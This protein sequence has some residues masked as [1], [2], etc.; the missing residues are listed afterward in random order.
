[1]RN[2]KIEKNVSTLVNISICTVVFG[3]VAYTLGH[4]L[5]HSVFG[6]HALPFENKV[7]SNEKQCIMDHMKMITAGRIQNSNYSTSV[8]FREDVANIEGFRAAFNVLKKWNASD[9]EVT[10]RRGHIYIF[11]ELNYHFH[12][13]IT[14]LNENY[15][16]I[17]IIYILIS[18]SAQ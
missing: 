14:N 3:V 1:M 16:I 2:V 10:L 5:T 6:N 8:T 12:C 18:L 11:Q 4:E 9:H 7:L 17:M 15:L 13:I